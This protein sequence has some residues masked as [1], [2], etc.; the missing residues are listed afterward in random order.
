MSKLNISMCQ[1]ETKFYLKGY[2]SYIIV[3]RFKNSETLI[4]EVTRLVRLNP[5]VVAN[6]PTAIHYLVNEHSVEADVPEVRRTKGQ[7]QTG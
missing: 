6:L 7:L 2:K 3:Y 5:I 1:K 4:K